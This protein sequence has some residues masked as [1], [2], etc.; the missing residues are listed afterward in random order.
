MG[1]FLTGNYKMIRLTKAQQAKEAAR[2]T[3]MLKSVPARHPLAAEREPK[4]G[5][6]ANRAKLRMQL[7]RVMRNHD[8]GISGA[9]FDLL[10]PAK[11][12]A[13]SMYAEKISRILNGD[14]NDVDHWRDITGYSELVIETLPTP[15]AG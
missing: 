7:E 5:N 14:S 2:H 3:A 10:S 6:F 1:N 11:Q 9:P 4:N 8:D 13:L 15:V 12:V